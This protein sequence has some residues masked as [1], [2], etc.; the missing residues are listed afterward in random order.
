MP[1]GV[2]QRERVTRPGRAAVTPVRRA[3]RP[4]EAQLIVRHDVERRRELGQHEPPV[5]PGGDARARAVQQEHSGSVAR[6]VDV[7]G[8]ATD[9]DLPLHVAN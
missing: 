5:R 1:E 2:D 4:A 6:L 9:L 3:A 8:N 7:G